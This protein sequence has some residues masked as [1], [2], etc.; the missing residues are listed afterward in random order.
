MH[1]RLFI[2]RPVW[3]Q[4]FSPGLTVIMSLMTL[5]W[6]KIKYL[7]FVLGLILQKYFH[8]QINVALGNNAYQMYYVT[9]SFSVNDWNPG[10]W[11][12][13]KPKVWSCWPKWERFLIGWTDILLD[14]SRSQTVW[15]QLMEQQQFCVFSES[16]D[17]RGVLANW[18]G[19]RDECWD[20]K[21][22]KTKN[23]EEVSSRPWWYQPQGWLMDTW[24]PA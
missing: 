21:E 22:W 4:R 16:W 17:V 18:W 11:I 24:V 10:K 1:T 20:S 23:E 14:R 2:L 7:F 19:R 13:L 3:N 15:S 6:S 8:N 5:T 12:R 9:F